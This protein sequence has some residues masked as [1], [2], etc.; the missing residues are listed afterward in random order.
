M[1]LKGGGIGKNIINYEDELKRKE[2]LV[3]SWGQIKKG[4]EEILGK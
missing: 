2:I 1:N 4:K 3:K